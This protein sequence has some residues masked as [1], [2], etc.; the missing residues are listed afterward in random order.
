M[1]FVG[2]SKSNEEIHTWQIINTLIQLS[3]HVLQNLTLQ[4]QYVKDVKHKRCLTNGPGPPSRDR[5]SWAEHVLNRV[6]FMLI[7]YH[8]NTACVQT[9]RSNIISE[10][11]SW[12]NLTIVSISN[13]WLWCHPWQ[14]PFLELWAQGKQPVRYE[15]FSNE[16]INAAHGDRDVIIR[17]Y[18]AETQVRQQW[19]VQSNAWPTTSKSVL[20]RCLIV[21][22]RVREQW[23]SWWAR[24]EVSFRKLCRGI[25]H[26]L[27]GP[28]ALPEIYL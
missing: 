19:T 12:V 1:A 26:C 17:I 22:L 10:V 6:R 27:P 24:G 16:I 5:A 9:Y 25:H 21:W 2:C 8:P 20:H 11:R 13:T 14:A 4:L 7:R 3:C 28:S 23:L 18:W 15:C